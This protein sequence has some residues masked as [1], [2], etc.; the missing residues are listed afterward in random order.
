MNEEYAKAVQLLKGRMKA[1]QV[2]MLICMDKQELSGEE[3]RQL[4]RKYPDEACPE[5]QPLGVVGTRGDAGFGGSWSAF[6]L[7][8][9]T[10]RRVMQQGMFWRRHQHLLSA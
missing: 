5:Q 3:L 2:G 8:L 9:R 1:V 7:P 4:L 10:K 6:W